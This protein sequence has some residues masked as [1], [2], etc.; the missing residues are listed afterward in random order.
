MSLSPSRRMR[1][2]ARAVNVWCGAPTRAILRSSARLLDTGRMALDAAVER[3]AGER[4]AR[5]AARAHVPGGGRRVRLQAAPRAAALGRLAAGDR[6]RR[7][8][9]RRDVIE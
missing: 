7:A 8:A 2:S 3:H 9:A 6:A 4:G 5:F 1:R